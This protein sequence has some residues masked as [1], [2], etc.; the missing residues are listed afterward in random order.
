MMNGTD[1]KNVGKWKNQISYG[2]KIDKSEIMS[3]KQLFEE[4]SAVTFIMN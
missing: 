3:D 2:S 4:Q 1:T